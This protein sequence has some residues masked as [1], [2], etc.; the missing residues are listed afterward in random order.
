MTVEIL[1][2]DWDLKSGFLQAMEDIYVEDKSMSGS[3]Y[4]PFYH[5]RVT[6][7]LRLL[8]Y[9]PKAKNVF[10]SLCE[11]IILRQQQNTSPLLTITNPTPRCEYIL[12][13]I[14]NA[15]AVATI[16]TIH[17]CLQW[18]NLSM[19]FQTK[20]VI[21]LFIPPFTINL[22]SEMV[23]KVVFDEAISIIC[24]EHMEIKEMSVKIDGLYELLMF[25]KNAGSMNVTN[26]SPVPSL[27]FKCTKYLVRQL[28]SAMINDV[29]KEYD[30]HSTPETQSLLLEKLKKMYET[31]NAIFDYDMSRVGNNLPDLLG[32]SASPAPVGV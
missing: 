31:M 24:N 28:I 26:D 1:P 13:L 5:L 25:A 3:T 9:K 14:K 17:N 11:Q 23:R 6:D 22:A 32:N 19:E 27:Q 16:E 30:G 20:L 29:K 8:A 18:N 10:K 7:L 15:D 4:L 21:I 12:K 2:R